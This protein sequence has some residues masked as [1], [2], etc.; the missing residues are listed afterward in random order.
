MTQATTVVAAKP[1]TSR[2]RRVLS[3]IALVLACL[4]I[5]ADDARGLDPPGRPQHRTDSRRSSSD[6]VTDPAVTDPIASRISVQVVDALGVQR[7]LEDRLPDA[8]KPLAGALTV[9]ITERIDERLKVA[10][11]NPR[12]QNAL[13]GTVSLHPRTG[14]PSA[15]RRN[16]GGERRRRLPDARCLPGGRG[17]ADG[18][19]IGGADPA[20]CPA[21]RP[22]FARRSGRPRPAA[23]D[24]PRRHAASRLRHDPADAGRAVGDRSDDRPRLRPGRDPPDRPERPPGGARALAGRGPPTDAHL[25]RHRCDRRVPAGTPGD[26]RGDE[27]DHRR[28]RRRRRRGCRTDDR[29]LGTRG[30]PRRDGPHPHRGRDPHH[31]RVPVGSA[32]VGRCDDLVRDRH[33]RACR[34]GGRCRGKRRRGERRRTR[35]GSRDGRGHRP[36]EPFRRREVRHRDHRVRPRLDRDRPRGRAARGGPGHRLPAA[37]PRDRRRIRRR[38][39]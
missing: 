36:R 5:L 23:R 16:R 26:E 15:A 34:F 27:R 17:G 25:S 12:L 6:A 14:R 38:R 22:D 8:L 2:G 31:R 11:Q 3:G 37:S 4:S 10:L 1:R 24:C 30:P 9:S 29:G 21:P 20:G 13:L 35:A 32:E 7:R 28:H 39:G 33:G 18:I 19:A